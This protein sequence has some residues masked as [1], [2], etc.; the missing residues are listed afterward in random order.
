MDGVVVGI[1]GGGSKTQVMVEDELYRRQVVVDAGPSNPNTVGRDQAMGVLAL[2]IQE[3][4]QK[5]G[6][7]VDSV[8]ALSA[9]LSG[10]DR[11][12]QCTELSQHLRHLFPTARVE[13]TNDALA[14]LTAGTQGQSGVVLIGGT[15]SIAVGEDCQGLTARSGGYGSLLGDEGGGFDLGRQGL[16]AAIQSAEERGPYTM[17]WAQAQQVFRVTEPF[18]LISQVYNASHPVGMIAGF[19]ERVLASAG[20]GDP[21]ALEIVHRALMA[22]RNLVTSVFQQLSS[23]VERKVVLAGGLLTHSSLLQTGLQSLLTDVSWTVLQQP[24][25]TGA[26]IRAKRLL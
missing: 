20:E 18:A 3:A 22:Y 25:V 23:S 11:P 15:G 8:M 6:L 1:D 14:A 16:Q 7:G 10:V 4:L 26:V 24:A 9:C 19:A 21:A 5:L 17:L 13:V 12:Q 2:A